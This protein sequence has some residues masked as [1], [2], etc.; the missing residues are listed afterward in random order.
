MNTAM[1]APAA[2]LTP[3]AGTATVVDPVCGMKV[4]VTDATRTEGLAG[5]NFHFCSEKCQTA[6]KAD[7]WF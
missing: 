7:P 1:S 5:Q 2:G 3:A 4:Q 6:F